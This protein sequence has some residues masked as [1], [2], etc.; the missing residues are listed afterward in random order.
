[1][2]RRDEKGDVFEPAH[3]VCPTELL[4]HCLGLFLRAGEW[5][6]ENHHFLTPMLQCF[7]QNSQDPLFIPVRPSPL[8]HAIPIVSPFL[9]GFLLSHRRSINASVLPPL[10]PQIACPPPVP[11]SHIPK[12]KFVSFRPCLAMSQPVF[13][14]TDV[15][16][17]KNFFRIIFWLLV[18][19][20]EI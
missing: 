19:C 3:F 16:P 5:S 14:T 8:V 7:P 10:L 4:T 2:S 13:F 20:G 12:K 18:W 9:V 1:M 17:G 6:L 11:A 15:F